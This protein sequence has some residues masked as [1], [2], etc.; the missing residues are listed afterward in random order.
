MSLWLQQPVQLLLMLVLRVAKVFSV[1]IIIIYEFLVV[2]RTSRDEEKNE[3][4]YTNELKL[5]ILFDIFN[6]K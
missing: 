4:E 5:N 3:Q 1:I 6:F 2:D